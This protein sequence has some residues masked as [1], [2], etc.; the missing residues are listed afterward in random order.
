MKFYKCNVCGQILRVVKDTRRTPVCCDEDMIMLEPVTRA[1]YELRDYSADSRITGA[2]MNTASAGRISAIGTELLEVH[3]PVYDVDGHTVTVCVGEKDHPMEETHRIEW[4]ALET[5]CGN[6]RRVL[7]A[8]EKPSVC[9]SLCDGDEVIA[10]YAYCNKHGL[11][12][13]YF[14]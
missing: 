1:S 5:R 2:N 14:K 8:G 13:G 3:L 7:K 4:I 6:Q 10:A 9:F 12:K 11:F